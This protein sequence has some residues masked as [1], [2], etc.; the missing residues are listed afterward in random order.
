MISDVLHIESSIALV[1]AAV[2]AVVVVYI[3]IFLFVR[4]AFNE[5]KTV[6]DSIRAKKDE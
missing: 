4:R 6:E 1:Y 5:E 3:I 2:G